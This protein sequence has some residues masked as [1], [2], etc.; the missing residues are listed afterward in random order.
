MADAVRERAARQHSGTRRDFS[1]RAAGQDDAEDLLNGIVLMPTESRCG[2]DF[3]HK[4]FCMR[5]SRLI[6]NAES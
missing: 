3:V 1:C 4:A 2:R 5:A 6:S